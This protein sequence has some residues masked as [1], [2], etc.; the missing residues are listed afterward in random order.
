MQY[1]LSLY[2]YSVL[3]CINVHFPSETLPICEAHFRHS[4]YSNLSNKAN[5]MNFVQNRNL[6]I[7]FVK[8]KVEAEMK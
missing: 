4:F 7:A 3:C 8:G 6:A 5:W 2:E 1:A